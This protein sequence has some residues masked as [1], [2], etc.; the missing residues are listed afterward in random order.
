MSAEQVLGS[1]AWKRITALVDMGP[2]V[3]LSRSRD[4]GAV[5]ISVTLDGDTE[6]DWFR[7]EADAILR[8]DEW[9]GLVGDELDARGTASSDRSRP[10]RGR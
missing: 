5:A 1:E 9:C 8:L 2:L 7:S 4:G 3:S 10:R 6:R